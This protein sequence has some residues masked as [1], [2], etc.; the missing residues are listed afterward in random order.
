MADVMHQTPVSRSPR[1]RDG[2]APRHQLSR[3][4]PRQHARGD[5]FRIPFHAGELSRNQN[6]RSRLQLQRLRQQRGRVDIRIAMNLAIPQKLCVFESR[7]HPQNPRLLA[8][9]QMILKS[10]QIVT[11][12]AQIL[13]AQLHRRVRPTPR[14]G[15]C[16]SR[17]L[18]RPKPQ[19]IPPTPGRLFDRQA[20]LEVLRLLPLLRLRLLRRGQRVDERLVLLLGERAIDVI[21]RSLVPARREVHL[22]H[23]DRRRVNNRRDRVIESQVITSGNRLQSLGQRRRGQRPGS[24][25]RQLRRTRI[26]VCNLFAHNPDPRLRLQP[27]LHQ[28]R[29]HLP[30]HRQR[31]PGRH[32]TRIRILQ[33]KTPRRPHLSLQEPGRTTLRFALQGVGT[34]QF[35]KIRRLVRLGGAMRPHLVQL[36]LAPSLRRL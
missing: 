30:I 29:K 13:A 36:H 33:Q 9:L 10:N 17:R 19:R 2:H 4:D 28:P 11:I 7:N 18:H 20:A 24:Q 27:F 8:K 35:G 14:L 32:R 15:I 3:E 23:V 21:G 26:Q 31:M 1:R 6:A 34:N 5:G 22:V 16:Q 25:N 12:R